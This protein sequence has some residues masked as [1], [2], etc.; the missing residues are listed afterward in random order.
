MAYAN[1]VDSS[2]AAKKKASE[3]YEGLTPM[4]GALLDLQSDSNDRVI[5][6]LERLEEKVPSPR[7]ILAS[8]G[9]L[10]LGVMVLVVYVVSIVAVKGGVDVGQAASATESVVTVATEATTPAPPPVEAAPVE[11]QAP[12]AA[13]PLQ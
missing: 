5:Q 9:S 8:A 4:E 12:T 13:E 6:A 2:K 3:R 10:M 1:S 11:A 7:V